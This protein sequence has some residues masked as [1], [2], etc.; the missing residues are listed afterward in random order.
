M[1]KVKI[2]G[3]A[4]GTGVLTIE[5]PNTN[6]DSTITL[7]DGTGTLLTE[8]AD[9]AIT[10]AK[11]ASGTDGNII[12]YDASGNPVAIATG[13]DG[14]VLTSAG[15]GSPPAFEDAAGGGGGGASEIDGLSDGMYDSGSLGLG[16]GALANDDATN[17][18]N[19]AVGYQALN[20]VTTKIW[21]TAVGYEALKSNT[22]SSHTAVGYKALQ[23]NTTGY[24][25]TAV[26]E[27]CMLSTTSGSYNTASGYQCMRNVT[28]GSNNTAFGKAALSYNTNGTYHVAIGKDAMRSSD[29]SNNNIGIGQKT[30]YN[31]SGAMNV[32][33][34]YYTA[35]AKTSGAS[36]ISIGENT[37]RNNTTGNYNI[38]MGYYAGY[39]AT[40]GSACIVMGQSAGQDLTTGSNN[41]LIGKNSGRSSAPS[42]EISTAD[43][44]ICLGNN[45]ITDIYCADTSISSSDGRDKTDVENFTAGL[46]FVNQMRP[47]TYRWDKRSWYVGEDSTSQDILDAVPD[48]TH[49]KTKQNIGFISQE[50]QALEQEIG[51]ATSKDNELICNTNGDDTAMGLKYER[52]VPILVNAIKELSAKVE[53]LENA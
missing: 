46:S 35:Y 23:G 2:Q 39:S 10:L 49:K 5:A 44:T 18:Y 34:G 37:H 4:S 52:L 30:L 53:A 29:G 36:N 28:T 15:A 20:S 50:V 42:G 9:N 41:I 40:T 19:T 43:D 45:D 13:T 32:G 38:T 3:N 17:N 33:I 27:N 11:M 14:Q 48:G 21:N 6:T 16:S 7:P 12:S 47:V 24:S 22:K 31:V 26:G 25:N 8:V 51:F 1:S